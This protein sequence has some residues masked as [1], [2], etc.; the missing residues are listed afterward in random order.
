MDG[1]IIIK[2]FFKISSKNIHPCL[3]WEYKCTVLLLLWWSS[4]GAL[5]Q[6]LLVVVIFNKVGI[7]I[8]HSV[9]EPAV[10]GFCQNHSLGRETQEY[11]L[12]KYTQFEWRLWLSEIKS[13]DWN[14]FFLAQHNIFQLRYKGFRNLMLKMNWNIDLEHPKGQVWSQS[15]LQT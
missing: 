8:L 11:N 15:E 14:D 9:S 2:T 10:W 3:T 12:Q 4:G 1:K 5:W 13:L 6:R 7:E